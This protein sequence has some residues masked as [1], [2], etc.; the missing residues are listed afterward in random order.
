MAL[1]RQT[2]LLALLGAALIGYFVYPQPDGRTVPDTAPSE[3]DRALAAFRATLTPVEIPADLQHLPNLRGQGYLRD[4]REAAV[5]DKRLRALLQRYIAEPDL[6]RRAEMT[7]PILDAW[8]TTSRR[9]ASLE[10]ALNSATGAYPISLATD[11]A[12]DEKVASLMHKV[13]SLEVVTGSAFF[14]YKGFNEDVSAGTGMLNL[15]SGAVP[16]KLD[17]HLQEG[18]YVLPM[19]ALNLLP[20]QTLYVERA[21][22]ALAGSLDRVLLLGRYQYCLK[23]PLPGF[24]QMNVEKMC[25]IEQVLGQKTSPWRKEPDKA[26]RS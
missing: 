13:H 15:L 26:Q 12:E 3:Q 21:Y 17:V 7:L 19:T 16:K 4:L 2:L 14:T 1:T 8:I 5:T 9:S 11:D 18:R 23:H 20:Q 22:K 10:E 6:A 25:R 24:E